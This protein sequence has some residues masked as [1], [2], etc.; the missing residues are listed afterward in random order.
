MKRLVLR[1]YQSPEF[2][3]FARFCISGSIAFTVDFCVLEVL[4]H[5]ADAPAH[6]AR[7]VSA[8]L[9]MQV[10]YLMNLTFTF[11]HQEGI[12]FKTWWRFIAGN[13]TGAAM[14]YTV[15]VGLLY[16]VLDQSLRLHRMIAIV[17]GTG[18][19]LVFNYWANRRFVFISRGNS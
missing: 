6:L 2:W 1:I 3:Q 8:P 13:V 19:G 11:R 9:A 14:N 16:L 10:A 7:C 5:F 17:A 4:I 12:S 15:F 18:V